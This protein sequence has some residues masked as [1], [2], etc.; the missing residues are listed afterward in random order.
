MT[1]RKKNSNK[2]KLGQFK[3]ARTYRYI[4][5]ARI[6]TAGKRNWHQG[7]TYN[8]KIACKLEPRLLPSN[9]AYTSEY[10]VSRKKNSIARFFLGFE[11]SDSKRD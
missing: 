9:P 7:L 2:I 1:A 8:L 3:A 11:I 4:Y 10:E 5:S 6:F